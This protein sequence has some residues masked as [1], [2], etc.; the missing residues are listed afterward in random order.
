METDLFSGL[1]LPVLRLVEEPQVWL[2]LTN[3][4]SGVE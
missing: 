4:S 2:V 3:I 1:K